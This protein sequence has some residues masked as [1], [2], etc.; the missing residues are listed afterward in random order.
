MEEAPR[1]RTINECIVCHKVVEY[2]NICLQHET[3]TAE[4]L[5]PYF[6]IQN[7][8]ENNYMKMT[9]T[10]EELAEMAQ[11]ADNESAVNGV[12]MDK[13][14]AYGAI[15]QGIDWLIRARLLEKKSKV[16][17]IGTAGQNLTEKG[18]NLQ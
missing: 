7:R 8:M 10:D 17:S 5:A 11:W 2:G 1:G 16:E 3:W 13:R 12:S 14:K 4:Q 18:K 9:Y 6:R 15:R